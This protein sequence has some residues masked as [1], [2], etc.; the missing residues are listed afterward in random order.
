MATFESFTLAT[1]AT[2]TGGLPAAGADVGDYIDCVAVDINVT[3]AGTTGTYQLEGSMDGSNW[4]AVDVSDSQ[5]LSSAAT[6]LSKTYTTTGHR[7]LFAKLDAGKFWRYF[8]INATTLT[9]QTYSATLW[10]MDR[11]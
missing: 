3:V 4:F 6:A 2:V 11:N 8:R 9:G 1:G 7:I 10:A 5:D